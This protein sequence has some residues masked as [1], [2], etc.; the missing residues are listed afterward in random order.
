MVNESDDVA[1]RLVAALRLRQPRVQ[2][3]IAGFLVVFMVVCVVAT[4]TRTSAW[5]LLPLASFAGS[6]VAAWRASSATDDR[7]VV[8]WTTV[9]AGGVALGFWLLGIINRFW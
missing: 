7:H 2:R 9:V 1:A 8:A 4:V 5:P 6:A 3:V